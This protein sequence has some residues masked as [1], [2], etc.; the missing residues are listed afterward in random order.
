MLDIICHSYLSTS[1]K[2]LLL[3]F[4]EVKDYNG[5]Y[6]ELSKEVGMS[7][8]TTSKGCKMLHREGFI[9]LESTPTK[10]GLYVRYLGK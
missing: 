8:K 7:P 4:A 5:T 2:I 1:Y 9:S 6:I 3:Y 10:E